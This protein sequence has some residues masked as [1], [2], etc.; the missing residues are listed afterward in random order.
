M[1]V[2]RLGCLGGIVTS[3]RLSSM[4]NS[5]PVEA[6]ENVVTFLRDDGNLITMGGYVFDHPLRCEDGRWQENLSQAM[7]RPISIGGY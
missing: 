5:F 2:P 4:G 1:A 6:L 7:L 3:R